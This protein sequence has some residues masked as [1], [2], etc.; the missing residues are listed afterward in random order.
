MRKSTR[1]L[2]EGESVLF[3][4]EGPRG[5][6]SVAGRWTP[7]PTTS[8]RFTQP[9]PYSS[10]R[11]RGPLSGGQKVA[12]RTIRCFAA[13]AKSEKLCELA[14]RRA[15]SPTLILRGGAMK[16]LSKLSLH[17]EV[18]RALTH[19]ETV[20]VAGGYLP[21]PS[22]LYSNCLSCH[23]VDC[24]DIC[25]TQLCGNT[26]QTQCFCTVSIGPSQCTSC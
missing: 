20:Q 3:R 22:K 5:L 26:N 19:Q 6:R 13:A 11:W 7:N 9:P 4:P 2:I 17:R 10:Y 14:R 8:V 1:L 23:S 12:S 25:G 18:I 16:R 24:T 15:K 21:P